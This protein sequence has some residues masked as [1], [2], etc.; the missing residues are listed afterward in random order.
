MASFFK[1]FIKGEVVLESMH[2]FS[3][4]TLAEMGLAVN[5]IL[6][7]ERTAGMNQRN[8]NASSLK[9]REE[10]ENQVQRRNRLWVNTVY[11]SCT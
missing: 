11:L 4:Q 2:A 10:I 9:V 1:K 6:I 8:R 7:R 5:Q 3:R